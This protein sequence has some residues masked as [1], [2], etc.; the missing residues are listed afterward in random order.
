MCG[1]QPALRM[2]SLAREML[3]TV[4][5]W[6]WPRAPCLQQGTCPQDREVGIG[7]LKALC[8]SLP[9]EQ[10]SLHSWQQQGKNSPVTGWWGKA[11]VR[12]YWPGFRGREEEAGRNTP[13]RCVSIP[14]ALRG[15]VARAPSRTGRCCGSRGPRS[16]LGAEH[17]T[18]VPRG[19][20]FRLARC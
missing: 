11:K 1:S 13:Q 14:P 2:S 7:G 10:G 12:G 20:P 15:A 9:G 6:R 19:A 18:G 8:M 4:C 16:L 3:P 5:L 17:P